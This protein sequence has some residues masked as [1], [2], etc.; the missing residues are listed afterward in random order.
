MSPSDVLLVGSI[1]GMWWS[2]GRARRR[3]VAEQGLDRIAPSPTTMRAAPLPTPTWDTAW[4]PLAG[5]GLAIGGAVLGWTVLGPIGLA[6]GGFGVAFPGMVHRRRRRRMEEV[7]E[8]QIGEL[9]AAV[10]QG[11]RSG[12]SIPQ[13][14]EAAALD[15]EPPMR[16]LLEGVLRAQQLGAPLEE[17]LGSL[18]GSIGTDDVRLLVL[19]LLT[20]ARSGGNIAVALQEVAATIR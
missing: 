10:A 3:A 20:H 4:P 15:A 2:L 9:A 5:A 11:V 1:V 7:L 17:A 12:L 14:I 18:A 13:G 6:C 16:P 19:I 8:G